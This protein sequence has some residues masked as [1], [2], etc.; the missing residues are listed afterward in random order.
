VFRFIVKIFQINVI[1][2]HFLLIQLDEQR[3]VMFARH[4]ITVTINYVMLSSLPYRHHRY[5]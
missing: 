5:L 4:V 1:A 2:V 3:I